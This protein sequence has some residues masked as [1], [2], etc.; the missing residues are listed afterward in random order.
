MRFLTHGI[1]ASKLAGI[2]TYLFTMN[3]GMPANYGFDYII[4]EKRTKHQHIIDSLG[5]RALFISPKKRFI[6]NIIDWNKLLR[7][8]KKNPE[9]ARL[10]YFNMYSLAWI[11]PIV[12]CKI[13]GYKVVIHAHNNNL[14]DCGV[15]QHILH[16]I[17]RFIIEH[18]NIYRLTNSHL[19]ALFFFGKRHAEM[20]YNAI[21]TCRFSFSLDTRNR[22]RC[23]LGVKEKNLYGFAGRLENSK[24]PMFLIDVFREIS[25][26][27]EKASFI[28]CGVGSLMEQ[29]KSYAKSN[30]IDVIFTGTVTNLQDY[31]Q[32]MDL[33]ILPSKYHWDKEKKNGQ[34][35]VYIR[36]IIHRLIGKRIQKL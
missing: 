36:R 1:S 2:E 18:M 30:N 3:K 35:Y 32:A 25:E 13:H 10:V 4:E 24:Q 22:I 7:N 8:E 29:V 27:D 21:D 20:I 16:T 14:H 5:S 31:Y 17:N 33:F 26:I 28:V 9:T 19:S 34:N 15:L 12:L 23:E 6:R 11:A